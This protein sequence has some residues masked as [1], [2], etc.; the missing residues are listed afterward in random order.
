[1]NK[2]TP[3]IHAY[4]KQFPEEIQ[5]RLYR[6]RE[7]AFE[8]IPEAEDAIKYR[9]P[10]IMLGKKNLFHYA[11][12][13]QHIGTYPLPHTLEVLQDKLACYKT[14]KGSVQ[15]PHDEALPEELIRTIIQTRLE[16]FKSLSQGGGQ[17]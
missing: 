2:V 1:M 15:F 14:G 16:E 5:I 13:K 3:E 17:A 10:T 7:L 8:L 4:I 11:A 9:M 12:Y 6:I